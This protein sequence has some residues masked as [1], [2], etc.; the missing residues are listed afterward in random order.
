MRFLSF[1][2]FLLVVLSSSLVWSQSTKKDAFLFIDNTPVSSKE[3]VRLYNKNL[4][5]IT[6][7]EQKDLDN[8]L[9]LFISYK[10]KLTEAKAL[11]LDKNSEYLKDIRAYRKDL[12][13]EYLEDSQITKAIL[14]DMYQRSLK[15][16]HASHILINLPT[17]A[18]GKDTVRAYEKINALRER[19]IA[20]EDFNELAAQYS[21]EPGAKNTK[22]DL[23]YFSGMQM[24]MS[25]EDAAYN[26]PIGDV[27]PVLRTGYG[28]HILKVHGERPKENKLR[29][30]HIMLMK[31]KDTVADE[32]RIQKAYS[33]LQDGESFPEVV[34]TYSQDAATIKNGGELD[35]FGRKDIKL[36]TFTDMAYSLEEGEYSKPF[37]SNL[38]WHIVLLKERLPE[39]PKE[40]VIKEVKK[41]FES[42]A[43]NVFYDQKKHKELLTI[44]DYE[45][46]Y[47][48]YTADLLRY[49]D[50]EYLIKKKKPIKLSETESKK[51]FK[52][53]KQTFY[54]NDFLNYL[55]ERKQYATKGMQTEQL[56]HEAL[57][58]YKKEKAIEVYSNKL[59]N[60][61]MAYT[62]RIDE[63][64]D[65]ILLFDL[66]QD[67][68]WRKA[69]QDTL[70]QKEYYIKH[71]SDFNLEESWEVLIYETKDK[72]IAQTILDKLNVNL[73]KEKIAKE[74]NLNPITETWSN[75][76]M[77]L[78]TTSFNPNN[79]RS[80]IK[81]G[82][83]YQ[84]V[85][86][87]KH[88]PETK[89][90]YETAKNDVVQAYV[91]AFEKQWE[92]ALRKKYKVK[93]KKKKWRKLKSELL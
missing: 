69:A 84:V 67:Q 46:L 75:D 53:E 66:M 4:D 18:Y 23:G 43:S 65:G 25:F 41:F 48:N 55:G 26:T 50:R 13:L 35:P 32:K 45:L 77:E 20:G 91:V 5:I 19:A 60:Q 76:S 38:G 40:E 64:N 9:D 30:A 51:L 79:S 68:V 7:E 85:E 87:Q 72:A 15:E 16:V 11:D 37:K 61:N 57:E 62:A 28:Y 54:Y 88:V 52:L 56:M 34:K 86:V 12:T 44:L 39:P 36:K 24:V 63:Y 49:I 82:D 90:D 10:L 80:I 59:Y 81:K 29:A 74:F 89:R 83:L 70:A 42:S 2:V 93:L 14:D 3:F 21:Q 8:Y 78:K 1:A 22:G 47:D 27:S 17:Y 33:A 71:E 31:S 58:N 92:E 73:D 6:D